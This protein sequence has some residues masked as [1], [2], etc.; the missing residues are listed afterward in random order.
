MLS[1]SMVKLYYKETL[2]Q[3]NILGIWELL[4]A[5]THLV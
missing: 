1:R 4:L 2:L 5:N 3:V